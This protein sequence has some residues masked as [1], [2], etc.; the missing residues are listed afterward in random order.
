[1]IADIVEPDSLHKYCIYI[2]LRGLQSQSHVSTFKAPT[3]SLRGQGS[4]VQD[5]PWQARDLECL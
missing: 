4:G 3:H 2:A 1:M 5:I